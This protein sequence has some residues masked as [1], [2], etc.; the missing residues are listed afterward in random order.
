MTPSKINTHKN[1]NQTNHI[2]IDLKN[3]NPKSSQRK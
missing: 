1:G 2:E 3:E